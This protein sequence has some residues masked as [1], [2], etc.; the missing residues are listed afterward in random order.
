MSSDNAA[1]CA[2]A[3]AWLRRSKIEEGKVARF[4]ELKTNRPLYFERR[5]DLYTLTYELGPRLPDHYGFVRALRADRLEAEYRQ[6]LAGTKVNEASQKQ[7]ALSHLLAVKAWVVI[8]EL[9]SRGAWTE[10]GWVRNAE[11]KK[12]KPEDGIIQSATFLKNFGQLTEY[13]RRVKP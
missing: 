11:G 3:L 5:G 8:K 1:T 7:A 13:V 9:D 10:E 2:S 12:V 4:Y 6:C